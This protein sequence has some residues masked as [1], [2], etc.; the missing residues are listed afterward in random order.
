MWVEEQALLDHML[1]PFADMLADAVAPGD[2][3]LDVGC[4]T[5]A[6]ALAIARK[7]GETGRYVGIDISE[8]MLTLARARTGSETN[9]LLANAQTYSFEP[10]SFDKIVS[11]FGVMFF[12][13]PVAAFTNLRRAA[14]D[15]GELRMIAWRSAGENPFMTAAEKAAAPFLPGMPP[16]DPDAPGQFAFGDAEKVRGILEQSG[17]KEI[18]LQPIDVPCS[19]PAAELERYATKLGPVGPA[20]QELDEET[21]ARVSEAILAAFA[22]YVHSAEVRF[23]AACWMVSA[24][25][26]E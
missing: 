26:H 5:G 24:R 15:D 8:P 23:N 1:Q 20:I 16:R 10:A 3:V 11:R 12:E 19:F 4:G 2:S 14:K 6:T 21:R 25:V 7:L 13:D 17:W 22:P 9:F 18:S